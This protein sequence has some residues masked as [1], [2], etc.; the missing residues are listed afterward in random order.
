VSFELR[1]GIWVCLF[2]MAANTSTN[3]LSDL[4]MATVSFRRAPAACDLSSLS[5]PV[6]V[7]V[8]V[9]VLRVRIRIRIKAVRVRVRVRHRVR[10]RVRHRVG[11]R[12]RHTSTG[13]L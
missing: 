10:V 1:K 2:P 5:L 4:L 3:E 11:V 12:V 13:C 7:R 8:S 9:R 6:R